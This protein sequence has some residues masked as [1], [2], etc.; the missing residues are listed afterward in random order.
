M[1][2]QT[3][4]PTLKIIWMSIASAVAAFVAL[5]VVLGKPA[6]DNPELVRWIGIF[7]AVAAG[8]QALTAMLLKQLIAGIANG[9]YVVYCVVRWS[10]VETIA[11][12]GL[13]LRLL[14]ASWTWGAVFLGVGLGLLLSMPPTESEEKSFSSEI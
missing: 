12:Y 13:I 10:L 8:I 1:S 11:V 3:P 4:I 5:S 9:R 7:L 6:P 2:E 14:G